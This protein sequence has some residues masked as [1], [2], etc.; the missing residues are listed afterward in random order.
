MNG[1]EIELEAGCE[2]ACSKTEKIELMPG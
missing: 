2:I 1:R